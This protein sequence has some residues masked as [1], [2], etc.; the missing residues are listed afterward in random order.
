MQNRDEGGEETKDELF[1]LREDETEELERGDE[2]K[3]NDHPARER[4]VRVV[5]RTPEEHHEL[6]E[7]AWERRR[8]EA[9]PLRTIPSPNASSSSF[10][11]ST[12]TTVANV[13]L[14][15]RED[16]DMKCNQLGKGA[17]TAGTE[18]WVARQRGRV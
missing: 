12:R 9:V 15:R 14:Q 11:I 18:S 8:W 1:N 4:A 16:L 17:S 3:V 7:K 6:G 10:L 13:Q 5:G 2:T